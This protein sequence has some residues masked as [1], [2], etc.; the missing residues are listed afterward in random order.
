MIDLQRPR[1]IELQNALANMIPCE[2]EDVRSDLKEM[3]LPSL[4]IYFMN[5]RDRFIPPRA[6]NVTTWERFLRDDRTREHW[7]AILK[8]QRR[9]E[10]GEDLTPFLSKDI[11]RYGYVRPKKGKDGKQRGVEWRDK[12]YVLNAYGIHHFHLTDKIKSKGWSKRTEQLLYISFSR[13]SAFF[14]MVG[15]HDSFD[16]GTLAQAV[17]EMRAAAGHEM[18]G[19]LGGVFNPA[20]SNKLQR[21]GFTTVAQ[22][23][24][25]V[26]LQAVLSSAGTALF[27]SK[28]AT[29]LMRMIEANELL[30]DQEEF[31][32]GWF[33]SAGRPCPAAPD[34][35]WMM[36]YC[37]LCVVEKSS[38][39]AFPLLNWHR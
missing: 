14:L 10:A 30:L 29:K 22:V 19:V 26:V 3:A 20:E 34:F 36:H 1:L 17:A 16:D 12:D 7:P 9:I 33:E 4:L 13:D 24:D 31:T 18:K 15:D 25:K 2:P 11:V 21:H 28:H 6:R 23:G 8:L 32:R 35:F 5:W 27:H 38:R 37:D 39:T